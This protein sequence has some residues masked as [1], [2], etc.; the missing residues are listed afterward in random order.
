M[1]RSRNRSRKHVE[2]K[3]N[4][5]QQQ[6]QSHL[7]SSSTTTS[8]VASGSSGSLQ[9][10]NPQSAVADASK[11]QGVCSSTFG[12]SPLQSKLHPCKGYLHGAK[13]DVD[14][15]NLF[16]KYPGSIQD[17]LR[18]NSSIDYSWGLMPSQV[19]SFPTSKAKTGLL[20]DCFPSQLDAMQDITEVTSRSSNHQEHQHSNFRSEF[21]LTDLGKQDCQGLRPFFN[22][23]PKARESWLEM[24]DEQS[25]HNSFSATRLSISIPMASSNLSTTTCCSPNDD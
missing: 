22:E 3:T 13:T 19:P 16:S 18:V 17:G 11:P 20:Y 10:I 15:H 25:E 9:S 14:E 24:D 1:H 23:W 21:G 12:S 7:S 6:S 8:H 5:T 2:S 4:L